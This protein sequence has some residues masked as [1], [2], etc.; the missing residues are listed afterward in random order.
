MIREWW[1]YDPALHPLKNSGI[2][3]ITRRMCSKNS[4]QSSDP[5]PS[6]DAECYPLETCA[7]NAGDKY[8]RSLSHLSDDSE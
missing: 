6:P 7:T 1:T 2:S 3:S 8:K 5:A 4:T